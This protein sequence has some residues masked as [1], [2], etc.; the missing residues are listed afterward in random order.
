MWAHPS[1]VVPGVAARACASEKL[2]QASSVCV[3]VC[4]GGGVRWWPPR[5]GRTPPLSPCT[6]HGAGW[7]LQCDVRMPRC[8]AGRLGLGL[9]LYRGSAAAV[10]ETKGFKKQ[11]GRSVLTPT[12]CVPLLRSSI[13]LSTEYCSTLRRWLLIA[14]QQLNNWSEKLYLQK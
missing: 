2:A 7:P 6:L 14:W 3:C 9:G 13:F 12:A 8:G 4:G 10:R 1:W 11:S 5:H